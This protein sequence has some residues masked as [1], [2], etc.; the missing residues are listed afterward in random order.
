MRL[1]ATTGDLRPNAGKLAK[2]APLF[3]RSGCAVLV[4]ARPAQLFAQNPERGEYSRQFGSHLGNPGSKDSAT[5]QACSHAIFCSPLSDRILSSLCIVVRTAA[6]EFRSF[7][8]GR[9]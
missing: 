6:F 2:S 8:E 1:A 4:A 9:E 7:A 3:H 5:L